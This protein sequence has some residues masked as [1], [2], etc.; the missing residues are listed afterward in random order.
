MH[1]MAQGKPP[2]LNNP[3]FISS[4]STPV[5]R[6]LMKSS[7]L[8]VK[9]SMKQ[10]TSLLTVALSTLANVS[11]ITWRKLPNARNLN[12]IRTWRMADNA[13]L[14]LFRERFHR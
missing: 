10:R 7:S 14:L 4:L 9:A 3:C 13:W 8:D 2:I 6:N 1:P 5:C 12:V 11:P